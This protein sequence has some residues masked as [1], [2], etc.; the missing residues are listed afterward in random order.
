MASD[1]SAQFAADTKQKELAHRL[2]TPFEDA[3]L[4]ATAGAPGPAGTRPTQ[5]QFG[6]KFIPET[7]D[8]DLKMRMKSQFA[9]D[10]TQL[11]QTMIEGKDYDYFLKKHK[12]ER[13]LKTLNFYDQVF[14]LKDPYQVQTIVKRCGRFQKRNR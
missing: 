4:D 14:D 1:K 10:E 8:E 6:G 9:A 12:Q 13:Y 3:R 5:R 7:P 2:P 11:G